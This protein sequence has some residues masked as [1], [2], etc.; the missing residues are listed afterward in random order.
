[1]GKEILTI[2]DASALLSLSEAEIERLLLAGELPGR[3]IGPH[4]FLSRQRLLQ[5]IE[6]DENPSPAPK[7]MPA[8]ALPERIL[9]P[10]WRC[11]ACGEQYGPEI[12]ECAACGTVRA[13]PLIGYRLPRGA[14]A[15]PIGPGGK[16][17]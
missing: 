14:A 17:N 1:M 7:P 16:V 9:S 3:R 15:A 2:A 11:R 4:W 5:F 12:A 10:G 8:A 13:T 6:N